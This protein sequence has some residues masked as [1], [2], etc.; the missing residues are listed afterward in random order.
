MKGKKISFDDIKNSPYTSAVA[1]VL[2]MI[3]IVGV[4]VYYVVGIFETKDKIVE[5]RE[6]YHKNLQ[7]II[8]LEELRA[9]SEKAE[10]QLEIYKG[11]LPDELGDVYILQEEVVATCRSFDLEVS[12]IE[13][14]QLP[15]ETQETIFVFNVQGTFSNLYSYMAH[16][17]NLEQMHRFDAVSITKG[18]GKNY[19]ATIS[20]A[21][22]S[23]NGASGVVSAVIDEAVAGQ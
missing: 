20:L 12:T 9:Q 22:L 14:T 6:S 19:A 15:A 7:E 8:V 10:A 4:I 5:A 17:S 13:V 23:Q 11:I 3:L 2:V 1:L 16:I 18:E 21:V